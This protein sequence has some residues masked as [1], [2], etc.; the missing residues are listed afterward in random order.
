VASSAEPHL[1]QKRFFAGLGLA[2]EGHDF[3][4]ANVLVG[5]AVEAGG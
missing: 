3:E 4:R 5:S 1:L 2:Q